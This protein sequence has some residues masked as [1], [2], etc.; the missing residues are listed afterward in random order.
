MSS[1]TAVDILDAA[2]IK[3]PNIS[4]LSDEFLKEI[5]G[6]ERKNLPLELLKQLLNDEIKLR[7]KKNPIK[8]KKF[9]EMLENAIMVPV[10]GGRGRPC[11]PLGCHVVPTPCTR[12][13][14]L[15]M[16]TPSGLTSVIFRYCAA[17]LCC[18]QSQLRY[19]K[20]TTKHKKTHS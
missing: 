18:A 12:L 13:M 3:K 20:A 19:I 16:A 4:M 2:G 9:P 10:D 6:M 8:S 15:L 5:K 11:P 1:E 7:T 17:K 14:P